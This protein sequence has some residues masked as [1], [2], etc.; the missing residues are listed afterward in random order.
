MLKLKKIISLTIAAVLC[1]GMLTGCGEE[2][3]TE[4]PAKEAK[5]S[6][7]VKIVAAKGTPY[8]SVSHLPGDYK[9]TE[10]EDAEKTKD[11][12]VTGDWD[13]AV[14]TP[15]EAAELYSENKNF[16]A[17]TTVS[18]GDWEIAAN[19]YGSEKEVTLAYL[20]GRKIYAQE[21]E[22]SEEILRA[23]MVKNSRNLYANQMDWQS[24][25]ELEDISSVRG[26][27]FM[28]DS[29]TIATLMEKD[30]DIKILFDLGELWQENFKSDIPGY[31]LVV[32]N[33]FV[34]D[35]GDEVE[36][37]LNDMADKLEDAQKDTD[38]KLVVYNSSNRGINIIK[39]FNE[40]MDYEEL[41]SDYYFYK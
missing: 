9:I 22:M 24:E 11:I 33:D 23:L 34:K 38:D 31:I 29:K 6:G 40:A 14:L 35:R 16:Q 3:A 25:E 4:E 30:D 19:G 37:V 28:A 1:V 5:L 39:K 21:S 26:T 17:V 27:T 10:T 18:L 13:F 12:I 32:N 36:A 41:S 8:A 20:S 15:V 7:D 2:K